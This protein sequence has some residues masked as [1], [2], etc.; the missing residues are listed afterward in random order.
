MHSAQKENSKYSNHCPNFIGGTHY[1]E[2]L[3]M[4][5]WLECSKHPDQ[6]SAQV[7]KQAKLKTSASLPSLRHLNRWRR[8]WGLSCPRGRP[9]SSHSSSQSQDQAQIRLMPSLANVGLILMS[10]WVDPQSIFQRIA[11]ALILARDD[12][13]RDH[14]HEHFEMASHRLTTIIRRFQALFFA[15][16]LGIKTLAQFDRQD[17]SMFQLL[18][19][20]YKTATMRQFLTDL[21]RIHAA[22][23]LIPLLSEGTSSALGYIDGHVFALWTNAKMH[24]GKITMLGRIMA[25]SQ[26]VATHDEHG[27]A[28]YLDYYPPDISLVT[29]IIDYC[30]SV[31]AQC[32]VRSFVIDREVNSIVA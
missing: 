17:Q 22:D 6:T 16:L 5:L 8:A 31:V 1:N 15:P 18:G 10:L 23:V 26:L 20:D 3:Q 25:G 19:F 32:G 9:P 13:V 24:K 27:Q 14:P 7:M 12:Y 29:V 4:V 30:G 28:L 2:P 21:E 11:E